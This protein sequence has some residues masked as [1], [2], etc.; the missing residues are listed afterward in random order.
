MKSL[1]DAKYTIDQIAEIRK[2]ADEAR[3]LLKRVDEIQAKLRSM[4]VQASVTQDLEFKVPVS[5]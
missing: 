2:L 4:G 5:L 3:G 1:P